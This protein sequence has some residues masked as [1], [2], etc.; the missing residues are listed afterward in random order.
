MLVPTTFVLASAYVN[1]LPKF[2]LRMLA[3]K[4]FLL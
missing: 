2:L 4:D 3:Y 1:R